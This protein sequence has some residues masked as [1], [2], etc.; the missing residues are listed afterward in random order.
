MSLPGDASSDATGTD[1]LE[2]LA[3]A[4]NEA[5]TPQGD[6]APKKKA[7]EKAEAPQ[8]EADDAAEPE[9]EDAEAA[10]S[11]EGEDDDEAED[12][13]T[14]EAQEQPQ[15]FKVKVDGEE[16][17]V[18]LDELKK[19]YSREAD[20]SRKTNALGEA[21]RA[22]EAELAAAKEALKSERDQYKAVLDYH[23][24]L[25]NDS[26]GKPEEL[27]R[28]RNSP[29][30]LERQEYAVRVA[31]QMRYREKQA[32]LETEKS[33]LKDQEKQEQDK[34]RKA[35]VA[36]ETQKLIVHLPEWKDAEKYNKDVGRIVTY[37]GNLGFKSD[38]LKDIVDHRIL[39]ALH[40]AARWRELESKPPVSAKPAPAKA[41]QPVKPGTVQAQP[42]TRSRA[43][44]AE[45]RLKSSGHVNDL[46]AV[47]RAR[48]IA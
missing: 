34:S 26:F 1:T 46:A 48:G 9:E 38:E 31:D 12:G 10:E 24:Q 2:A 19:G 13:E 4:F 41:V 35:M 18:T 17:E 11:D 44:K 3:S 43:A 37:A 30:P 28:L 47:F 23:Q 45:A 15:S 20:Y 36:E 25:I 32:A 7:E 33:R 39:R 16:L 6:S 42:E 5:L 29:D 40:D 14:L 22:H 27:E 21:K 8:A